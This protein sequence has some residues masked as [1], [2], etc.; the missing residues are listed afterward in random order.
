EVNAPLSKEL[1]ASEVG[2]TAAFLASPLASAITGSIVYV[3]NGLNA[4][5]VA[6]DSPCLTAESES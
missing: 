6:V 5:G 4:M 1:L 2:Y 3:D